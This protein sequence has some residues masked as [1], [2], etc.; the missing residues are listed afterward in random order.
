[1]AEAT[2]GST[3]IRLVDTDKLSTQI[4]LSFSPASLSK[5][6]PTTTIVVTA[7]LNGGKVRKD[8]RFPLIIDEVATI[9]AGLTRDVDY[10]AVP[11]WITIPDRRVSGKGTIVFSPLNKKVGPVWV[12]AGGDP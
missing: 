8:L 10:S 9:A 7:T 3:D 12:K 1:M 4:D 2:D 6:D 11:S 5:N